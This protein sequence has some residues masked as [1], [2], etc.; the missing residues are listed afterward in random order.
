MTWVVTVHGCGGSMAEA[1]DADFAFSTT[2]ETAAK[3]MASTLQDA[4]SAKDPYGDWLVLHF[5]VL[6]AGRYAWPKPTGAALASLGPIPPGKVAIDMEAVVTKVLEDGDW[7]E[8]LP[9]PVDPDEE[10]AAIA[11]ILGT[12]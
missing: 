5:E 1:A 6:P 7:P 4:L 11:S 12:A 10:A 9:P 2:D 3:Q 8:E